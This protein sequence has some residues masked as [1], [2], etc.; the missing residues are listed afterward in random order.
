[1]G[2]VI[3]SGVVLKGFKELSQEDYIRIGL[4]KACQVIQ[5][6]ARMVHDF[7][8]KTNKLERA[9]EY[10]VNVKELTGEVFINNDMAPYGIFVH[11]PT[12][13]FAPPS[14]RMKSKY[15]RYED[16]SYSLRPVNKQMLRTGDFRFAKQYRHPGSDADPFIYNAAKTK[17]DE[18][19]KQFRL[20]VEAAIGGMGS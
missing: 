7:K 20:Q 14:K 9:I 12:G 18:A 11:E 4:E 5:M 19:I 10:R 16:G 1:M 13:T 8:S 6:E 15:H 2:L 3:D 17:E